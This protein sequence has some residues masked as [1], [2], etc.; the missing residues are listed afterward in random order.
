MAQKHLIAVAAFLLVAASASAQ[1]LGGSETVPLEPSSALSVPDYEADQTGSVI[2][3]A[4][5]L[6]EAAFFAQTVVMDSD[7]ILMAED[8]FGDTSEIVFTDLRVEAD[9]DFSIE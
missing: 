3:A 2:D 7:E 4:L 5:E 1:D 9:A 8:F 6:P